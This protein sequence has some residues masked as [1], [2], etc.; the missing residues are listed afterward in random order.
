MR[1]LTV[2]SLALVLLALP[3]VAGAPS[4]N[5]RELGPVLLKDLVV[6][7]G[8]VTIWVSSG[9]CTEK[10]S[11]KP[12][13]SR[14]KD[15]AGGPM[16]YTV[17]FERVREDSCKAVQHDVELVY[18]VAKDLGITGAYTLTVANPVAASSKAAAQADPLPQAL[19]AATRRAIEME[20][21]SYQSRLEA[22]ERGVGPPENVAKFK[23]KLAELKGWLD[24]YGAMDPGQYTLGTPA[25]DAAAVLEDARKYGPVEPAVKRVVTAWV[26]EVQKEGSTL[27][28]EE[29][30]KSGPFYHMAGVVGDD[31]SRFK[32]G[33][34]YTLTIYLVYKREYF[35]LVADYYVYVADVK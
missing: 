15:P 27:F 10:A 35:G 11:I 7:E 31:Y 12:V 33:E 5:P 26:K 2:V 28:L 18:D 32:L 30:S 4:D 3:L 13:L 34:K 6:K 19:L 17:T 16:R 23:G 21:K 25:A 8:T 20:M 22:A 14:E 29:M 1:T 24:K 9:G